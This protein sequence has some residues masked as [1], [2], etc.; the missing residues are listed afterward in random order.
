[1][2]VGTDRIVSMRYNC[3]HCIQTW[4]I[5]SWDKLG[6]GWS[7]SHF[8]A[9]VPN[10]IEKCSAASRPGDLQNTQVIRRGSGVHDGRGL[11]EA[12]PWS[13]KDPDV[14]S[15][16]PEGK[17]R[18]TPHGDCRGLTVTSPSLLQRPWDTLRGSMSS[19]KLSRLRHYHLGGE[20]SSMVIH[21][22]LA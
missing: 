19:L 1:M 16:D 15:R 11:G 21:R 3:F 18:K 13:F 5:V 9:Q 10:S 17:G 12:S 8:G 6:S 20:K 2:S 14:D 22:I 4:K 7:K